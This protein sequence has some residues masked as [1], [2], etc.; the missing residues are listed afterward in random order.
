MQVDAS[1]LLDRQ[2]T[3]R[4]DEPGGPV[5]GFEPNV[6]GNRP[7][8]R[9]RTPLGRPYPPHGQRLDFV[10]TG[11]RRPARQDRLARVDAAIP[12]RVLGARRIR[13]RKRIGGRRRHVRRPRDA[14]LTGAR[15]VGAHRTHAHLRDFVREG[16]QDAD[17]A[18]VW[19]PQDQ[20]RALLDERV[21]GRDGR[22]QRLKPHLHL[23][24]DVLGVLQLVRHPLHVGRSV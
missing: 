16:L 19:V 12:V 23:P 9:E 4:F 21:V 2:R 13:H 15:I 5:A 14:I 6:H 1:D 7:V 17:F 10:P 11:H 18:Q 20:V 24:V 22:L 8:A 3:G